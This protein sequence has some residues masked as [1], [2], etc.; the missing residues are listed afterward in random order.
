MKVY[1]Y[2]KDILLN[3]ASILFTAMSCN[4]L[5]L[6]FLSWVFFPLESIITSLFCVLVLLAFTC[7]SLI[8][9]NIII[10]IF[11]SLISFTFLI[12]IQFNFLLDPSSGELTTFSWADCYL[13]RNSGGILESHFS[14][15]LGGSFTSFQC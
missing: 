7:L 15:I 3:Y 2:Y 5:Q 10:L 13:T 8:Q 12:F 1:Y 9:K 4:I 11:T 14:V 6:F